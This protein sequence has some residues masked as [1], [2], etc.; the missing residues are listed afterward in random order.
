M[1][2]VTFLEVAMLGEAVVFAVVVPPAIGAVEPHTT[3]STWLRVC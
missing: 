3:A 2:N 1:P